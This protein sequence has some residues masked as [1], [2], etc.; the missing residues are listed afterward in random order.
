MKADLI[1]RL[2]VIVP[3]YECS[4]CWFSC[5][6]LTC[7]DDRASDKCD[8]GADGLNELHAEAVEALNKVKA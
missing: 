8:C 1:A 4:D 7:D 5:A 2:M 3:H 6:T